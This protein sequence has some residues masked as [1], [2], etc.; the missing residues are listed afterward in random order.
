MRHQSG[1]EVARQG[2]FHHFVVFV[3]A[4]QHD[5]IAKV[6][7][8]ALED[9]DEA[10]FDGVLPDSTMRGISGLVAGVF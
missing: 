4:E 8:E 9:A 6:V 10:V 7:F 2:V 5:V 1:R 3:T